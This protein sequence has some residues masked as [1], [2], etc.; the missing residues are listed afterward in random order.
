[1]NLWRVLNG[2]WRV[3]EEGKRPKKRKT[4]GLKKGHTSLTLRNRSAPG[5][6]KESETAPLKKRKKIVKW[7][8]GEKER[9]GGTKNI[10]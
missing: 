1:L 10:R 7:G 3:E 9:K 4:G 5:R 8:E 2:T 6:V